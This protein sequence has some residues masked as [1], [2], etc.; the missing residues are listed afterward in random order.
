MGVHAPRAPI[1]MGLRDTQLMFSLR[2]MMPTSWVRAGTITEIVGELSSGRTS[3]MTACLRDVTAAGGMAAL[4]DADVPSIPRPPR[5]RASCSHICC[6]TL[7]RASRGRAGRD[8]LL[9]RCPGWALVALDAGETSPRVSL[10][11]AFRLRQAARRAGVALL[12]VGRRRVAGAGATLA[13]R[14]RRD[15]LAWAGSRRAPTRLAGMSTRVQ[16]LR[17]QGASPSAVFGAPPG[18][19]EEQQWWTA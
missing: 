4:V 1:S 14:T 16:V 3:L 11:A 7:W 2:I 10:G 9:A 13:V 5:A 12:L 17:N 8:G 15:A 6:G 19:M 18:A